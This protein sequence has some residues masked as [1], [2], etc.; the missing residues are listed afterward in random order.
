MLH[1]YVYVHV[2]GTA[3]NLLF[4]DNTLN[5]ITS[6]KKLG[7]TKWYSGSFKGHAEGAALGYF[8]QRSLC[9]CALICICR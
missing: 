8:F 9:A 7:R 5:A 4:F 2:L 6:L 3:K 1:V